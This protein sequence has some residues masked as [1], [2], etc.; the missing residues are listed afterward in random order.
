MKISELIFLKSE[1]LALDAYS[2]EMSLISEKKEQVSYGNLGHPV[3][4]QY[5]LVLL[6]LGVTWFTL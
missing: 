6:W 5:L 3:V 1:S 4:S 2:S